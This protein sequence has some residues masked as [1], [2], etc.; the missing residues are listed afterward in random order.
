MP[1]YRVGHM[2]ILHLLAVYIIMGSFKMYN[3]IIYL[4]FATNLEF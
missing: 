3:P 1:F 2:K 4:L